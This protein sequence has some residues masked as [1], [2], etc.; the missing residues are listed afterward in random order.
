LT[1]SIRGQLI[2][3][4]GER[5]KTIKSSN[6]YRTDVKNVYYDKIPMGIQLNDWEV[7]A[8]FLLDRRE[9]QEM[10][11]RVLK[12]EWEFSLQLWADG[13]WG[14]VKMAEFVSDVSKALFANS[15]T[16]E[17]EDTFRHIHSAITHILP[18]SVESDLNMIEANRIQEVTYL[19]HY[20]TKLFNM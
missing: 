2:E 3:A 18:Y 11:H 15:P 4:L 6:G 20:R 17:R 10:E 16:A 8:I 19:V 7:P 9:D 5:L 1:D 13:D 14:D 12:G